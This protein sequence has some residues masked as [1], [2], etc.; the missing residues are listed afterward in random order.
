MLVFEIGTKHIKNIKKIK[1]CLYPADP[2]KKKIS[3][4]NIPMY[5]NKSKLI[6]LILKIDKIIKNIITKYK[7]GLK[8]R[9]SLKKTI[10]SFTRLKL[11]RLYFNGMV[12]RVEK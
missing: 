12:T 3:D 7:K 5:G 6:F 8:K 10:N 11:C 4:K 1:W 2:R 9:V